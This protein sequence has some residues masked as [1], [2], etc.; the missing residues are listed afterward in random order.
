MKGFAQA[1]AAAMAK[2]SPRLFTNASNKERRVGR[3]YLDFL[4]NA[5]GA[6]AV[7]GYSLRANRE[8]TVATPIGWEELRDL[9]NGRVFDRKTVPARLERLGKDPWEGLHSAAA[10]ISKQAQRDVGMK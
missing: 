2:D 3:I 8:F 6:T 9:P 7:G 10:T 1:F 4:R 5:R